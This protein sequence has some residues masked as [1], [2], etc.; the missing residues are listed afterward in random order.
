MAFVCDF[1]IHRSRPVRLQLAVVGMLVASC[2]VGCSRYDS[3]VTGVV[4]LDGSPVDR[5]T[6]TFYPVGGGAAAYGQI[7]PDGTYRMSTGSE[8]GLQ[9]G[10]YQVAVRVVDEIAAD[11]EWDPPKFRTVIPLRY[12]NPATSGFELTVT[13]G[14]NEYDIALSSAKGG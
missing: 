8:Q 10:S 6:L 7:Q 12:K 1:R 4:T 9:P 11:S 13:K 14:R 2:I 3:Q 5:G